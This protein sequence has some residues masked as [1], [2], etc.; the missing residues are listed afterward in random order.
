MP[1]RRPFESYAAAIHTLRLR[2][3]DLRFQPNLLGERQLGWPARA[4]RMSDDNQRRHASTPATSRP[5]WRISPA[6]LLRHL[7]SLGSVLYLP[8]SPSLSPIEEPTRGLLVETM[9]LAPL[10][11][12]RYLAAASAI[13]SEGPR[14]WIDCVDRLGQRCARLY[15]LPD[16]DYLAW[17]ALSNTTA[18]MTSTASAI[19]HASVPRYTKSTSAHVLRFHW[20]QLAG[21]DVLSAEAATRVSALSEH[22]IEQVAAAEAVPLRHIADA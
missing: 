6:M 17:D 4:D 1:V 8:M 14:E 2:S 21:L 16:T 18:T 3:G 5:C 22:L 7:P 20:R 9:R 12:T 13:T 10:L 15:L 19:Q 11:R